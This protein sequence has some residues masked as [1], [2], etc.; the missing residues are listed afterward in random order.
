MSLE[1]IGLFIKDVGFP[2]FICCYLL[3]RH[4][5]ILREIRTDIKKLKGRL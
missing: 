5:K 1:T 3:F 4:D 2:V